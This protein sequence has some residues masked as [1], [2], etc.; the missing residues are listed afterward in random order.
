MP[1]SLRKPEKMKSVMPGTVAALSL[2]GSARAS[3]TR[4]FSDPTLSE[5]TAIASTMLEAPATGTMLR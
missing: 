3:A 1:L 4:S 2:P 5:G